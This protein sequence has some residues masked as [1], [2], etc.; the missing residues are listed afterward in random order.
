M[1]G[2]SCVC[3]NVL[4]SSNSQWRISIPEI[5][6]KA[7]Y[8]FTNDRKPERS[9]STLKFLFDDLVCLEIVSP[10]EG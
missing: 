2:M 7:I 1:L 8:R 4:I 3:R 5:L 9:S 10:H 6:L